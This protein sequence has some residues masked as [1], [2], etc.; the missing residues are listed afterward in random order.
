MDGTEIRELRH[1]LGL[2]QRELGEK[3]GS[4]K[5]S[6]YKWESKRSNPHRMFIAKLEELA[7]SLTKSK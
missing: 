6:V 2:S 4:T 5:T 1:K 7:E 3:I